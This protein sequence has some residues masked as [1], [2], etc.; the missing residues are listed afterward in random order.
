MKDNNMRENNK[1]YNDE[2]FA[3]LIT[4]AEKANQDVRDYVE[5]MVDTHIFDIRNEKIVSVIP[6]HNDWTPVRE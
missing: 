3:K 2:G 5:K 4:I 1:E 6:D